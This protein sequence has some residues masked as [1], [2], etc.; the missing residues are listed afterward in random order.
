MPEIEQFAM[1]GLAL[2]ADRMPAPAH[3]AGF[4]QGEPDHQTQQAGLA[5][6]VG[7]GDAQKPAGLQAEGEIA[8]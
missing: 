8:E 4:G 5:D 6:T 7:A 1:K 2:A 3:F